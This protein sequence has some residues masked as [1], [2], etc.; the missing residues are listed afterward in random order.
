MIPAF[1]RKTPPLPAIGDGGTMSGQ[2]QVKVSMETSGKM[3]FEGWRKDV[4]LVIGL[5]GAL[6]ALAIAFG[7][8]DAFYAFSRVH[9]GWEL[10]EIVIGALAFLVVSLVVLSRALWREIGIRRQVE[11]D[12]LRSLSEL[13]QVNAELER[14]AFVAAHDLQEPLRHIIL[15]TQSIGRD[16]G[17]DMG[18]DMAEKFDVVVKAAARMRA[19]IADVLQYSRAD[20][21]SEPF[22]I[23][24][25][26]KAVET[27]KASL[28]E[29]IREADAEILVGELPNIEGDPHQVSVLFQNMIGNAVKYRRP[30]VPCRIEI[31]AERREGRWTFHVRDNGIGIERQYWA[32]I[33][34]PF[35]RLHSAD[36]YPGT[37]IGL[38]L[39]RRIVERHGGRIW[40]ESEP[41]IGSIF[42]FE[43]PFRS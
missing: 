38:A 31:G 19:L 21:P 17:P 10:D 42:R 25:V 9:E 8:V 40:V 29:A 14:F 20:G 30:D 24:D 34:D 7:A 18:P 43:L 27:A 35:R 26:E 15:Y 5:G 13:K 32:R 22:R 2:N 37:G 28:R 11:K 39:C 4:A 16:L 12:L 3:A 33:F 36:A 1:R 23:F 41:G 6:A